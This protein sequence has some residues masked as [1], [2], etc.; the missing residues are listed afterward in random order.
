MWLSRFT[1]VAKNTIRIKL[2]R[3]VILSVGFAI[4]EPQF[5]VT[6]G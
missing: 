3:A 2:M 4:K 6:Y 5:D 1:I